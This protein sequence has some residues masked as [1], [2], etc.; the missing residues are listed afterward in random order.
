[1]LIEQD[2]I[3]VSQFVMYAIW[4]LQGSL[5]RLPGP[6]SDSVRTREEA[7]GLFAV[8][9]FSGKASEEVANQ[10]VAELR[11]SLRADRVNFDGSKWLLARYNDPSTRPAFR[12][13]EVLVP[14][15]EFDLWNT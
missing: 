1:M 14:V 4:S 2:C 7:G 9:V 3:A 11:D 6:L 15:N 12:R 8:S 5:S 13:N 10:K